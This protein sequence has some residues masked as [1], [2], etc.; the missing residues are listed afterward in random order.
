MIPQSLFFRK[1]ELQGPVPKENIL[2]AEH[3]EE[4]GDYMGVKIKVHFNLRVSKHQLSISKSFFFA[5]GK[6]CLLGEGHI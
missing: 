4:V 1:D 6:M 3:L 2:N 5:N